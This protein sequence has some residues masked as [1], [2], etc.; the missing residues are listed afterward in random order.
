MAYRNRCAATVSL[1][2]LCLFF[3][4][5]SRKVEA[6]NVD[7]T[8]EIVA[9]MLKAYGGDPVGKIVSVSARGRIVEFLNGKEGSYRRYLERPGKLRVEVMPEQG[10]E[11]RVLDGNKGWQASG[12]RFIPVSPLELQSMKYQYR[13]LDLPMGLA[14]KG[15]RVVYGGKQRFK[16]RE[17]LLLLIE[18][19]GAPRLSVL[20]DAKTRLIVRVAASFAMGMMGG[21]ELSTE[22]SDFRAVGGVLFP[23]KLINFAGGMKLSEIML[24][25]IEVNRGISPDLFTPH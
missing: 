12:E 13:Y 25:S 15:V 20:V 9:S 24:D 10:G 1:L 3:L 16:E 22:Y 19:S 6:R 21:G 5:G 11:V 18:S 2:L 17:A 23:H 4:A 8:G 14:D 7:P